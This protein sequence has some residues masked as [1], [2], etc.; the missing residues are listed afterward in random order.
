MAS[1]LDRLFGRK[2]EE[3]VLVLEYAELPQWLDRK[4]IEAR[5]ELIGQTVA[6]RAAIARAI[7]ETRD[8]VDQLRMVEIDEQTPPKLKRVVET[9]LQPFARAMDIT[10][11]R[12][13]SSD[14]VEFYND[15]AE[16]LKGC[17][18]HMN[19]PGK[20]ITAVLPEEMNGIK[21]S[22]GV[23]GM[24]VNKMTKEIARS[25][26]IM[27]QLRDARTSYHALNDTA[28]E[29][30]A[31]QEQWDMIWKDIA[32]DETRLNAISEK[33]AEI[34]TEESYRAVE[35]LQTLV[36]NLEKEQAV[37]RDLYH[38]LV[39]TT[40]GVL[41]R[42]AY[43]ADRQGNQESARRILKVMEM[44]DEPMDQGGDILTRSVK[45]IM[46]DIEAMVNENTL[47]LKNKSELHLFSQDSHLI[48][49]LNH[50]C[51]RYTKAREEIR[52]AKAKIT[53]SE[54]RAALEDLKQRR[55]TILEKHRGDIDRIEAYEEDMDAI[56]ASI[57]R[58]GDELHDRIGSIVGESTPFELRG[59]PLS[60]EMPS[61]AS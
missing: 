3:P 11:S 55:E 26:R 52:A 5:N 53:R 28:D 13:F 56:K 12:H 42:A 58:F 43:A 32:K 29:Y 36:D 17:V 48:E 22:I 7:D 40:G 51:S 59:L 15:A 10:L 8:R 37:L 6:P 46:P 31:K 38:T 57:P 54:S 23:I 41:R 44:L 4:E 24:E 35:E 21:A 45:A 16:V 33:I 19:G 30:R 27:G 60:S 1:F 49:E 9:S 34:E 47:V 14:P 39:S 50:I 25:E 20:Y 61:P 2:P 18:K